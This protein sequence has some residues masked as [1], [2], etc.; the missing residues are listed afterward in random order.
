MF[1]SKSRCHEKNRMNNSN[2]SH[3]LLIQM[4]D[5]ENDM[6]NNWSL[7]GIFPFSKQQKYGRKKEQNITKITALW[8]QQNRKYADIYREIYLSNGEH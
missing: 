2:R 1:A 6:Q 7:M 5:E 8:R 4:S 3:H